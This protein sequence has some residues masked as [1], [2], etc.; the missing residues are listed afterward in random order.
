MRTPPVPTIS[1]DDPL[2]VEVVEAIRGGDVERRRLSVPRAARP[3]INPP[4]DRG[5]S[6]FSRGEIPCMSR[7]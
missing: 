3:A 1:A 6:L 7:L 2:A 4:G 5:I